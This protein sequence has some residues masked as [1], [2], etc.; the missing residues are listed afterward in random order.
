V[1]IE[2][3]L[4]QAESRV[5]AVLARDEKLLKMFTYGVDI[6]RVTA[7]WI[8]GLSVSLLEQFF[9]EPNEGECKA[10]AKKINEEMKFCTTEEKRQEGKKFRHA[11]HYDMGKHEASVQI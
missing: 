4:S 6:H 11:G 1:F 9:R 3:D 5:V 10:L 2:P 7:S 8:A